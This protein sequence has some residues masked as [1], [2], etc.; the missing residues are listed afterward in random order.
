MKRVTAILLAAGASTRMNAFKQLLPFGDRTIVEA[1]VARILTTSIEETIVVVGHRAD[2]VAA[3][4]SGLSVRVVRNDAYATGMA[5]SVK[6]GVAAA[7]A[8]ADAV[9]ICLCDQPHVPSAVYKAVLDTYRRTG[10]LIVVPTIAGDT[11]HPVVFDMSLVDEILAVDPTTG[12]RAV[13]YAHRA[14]TIRVPVDS[15]AIL[16]DMDTPD[17]YERLKSL[18]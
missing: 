14:D 9:M 3:A 15:V 7:R 6:A 5:S 12:L 11:G 10:A 8:T 4:V 1:C 16:D 2:D 18:E 17:D 13:T